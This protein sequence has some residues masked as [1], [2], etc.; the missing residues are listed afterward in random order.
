VLE[1]YEYDN[2]REFLR[3]FC[4]HAKAKDK[5]YSLRYFSRLAG[6][7]SPS[8]LKRVIDGE[9]N[10]SSE[11]ITKFSKVLKLNKRQSFFFQNLTLFN[12]AKTNSERETYAR[13]LLKSRNFREARPLSQLQFQYFAHWYFVPVR[14]LAALSDFREDPTWIADAIRPR[15]T[16]NE[17]ARALRELEKLGLLVRNTSGELIQS[18][19]DLIRPDSFTASFYVRYHKDM[20][21]RGAESIELISREKRDIS[22]V[23]FALSTSALVKI[24]EMI[25]RLREEVLAVAAQD[26]DSNSIYQLNLQLFPIAETGNSEEKVSP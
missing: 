8:H 2:F 14:E 20:I 15:I 22:T 5:K 13:E 25:G 4:A 3:D 17:A 26:S 9:R 7:V 24:K 10:L 21:Q 11:A 12:Q 18:A 1:I 16:P 19:T 6:F 23:S